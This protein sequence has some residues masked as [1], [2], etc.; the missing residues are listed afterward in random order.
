MCCATCVCSRFN[1][2]LFGLETR[3]GGR[4]RLYKDILPRPNGLEVDERTKVKGSPTAASYCTWSSIFPVLGQLPDDS[5]M[6]CS[7]QE[8][9]PWSAFNRSSQ[10]ALSPRAIV[11]EPIPFQ[12]A[13]PSVFPVRLRREEIDCRSHPAH[14]SQHQ[15][16]KTSLFF[17]RL[18][19]ASSCNGPSNLALVPTQLR[20]D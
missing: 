1:V 6:A 7:R 18:P 16:S 8:V 4:C 12:K 11:V 9:V 2:K 19:R 3:C 5:N 17:L 10:R 13:S 20:P 14:Y 15:A